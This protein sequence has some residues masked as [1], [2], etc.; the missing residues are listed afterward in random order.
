MAF[1]LTLMLGL[2]A[3][4]LTSLLPPRV[5]VGAVQGTVWS[6]STDALAL[7]GRSLG[8]VRWRLRPLQLFLGRLALDAELERS[9]GQARAGLRLGLGGRFEARDLEAHLP[10]AALPPGIAPPGWSGALRADLAQLALPPGA[11]PRIEGSVELR[12]LKAPP[13][14]GAA[15]GSYRL[16]FDA[17]SKQDDRLVGTVQDLEGPMQVSGTLS[18][19]ADRSYVIEGLVAPRAD[20][21]QAV[22]D[23]LRFLGPPDAQGSRPFSVAGTY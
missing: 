16:L 21:S 5:A 20:A 19:G 11:V 2:P 13:P 23:T 1:A 6:G 14:Q 3:Q 9:D 15:I 18:L 12:N 10:I 22:T 8:A 17:A 7:D 4:V